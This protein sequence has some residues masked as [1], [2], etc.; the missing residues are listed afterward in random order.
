MMEDFS[1]CKF[2]IE[3]RVTTFTWVEGGLEE[4]SQVEMMLELTVT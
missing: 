1:E 3:K 2:F 4:A